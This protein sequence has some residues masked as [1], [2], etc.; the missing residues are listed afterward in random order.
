MSISFAMHQKSIVDAYN[1]VIDDK[2][3]ID[4]ALFSYK[5]NNELYLEETGDGG[6]EELESEFNSGKIQYAFV[7]ITDPNTKMNKF[8]LIIWQGDGVP[9][10]RKGSCANHVR[11]VKRFF[12]NHHIAIVARNED[13]V[14][15]GEIMKQVLKTT[16]NFTFIAPSNNSDPQKNV[17]SVY[18]PIKPIEEIKNTRNQKFWNKMQQEEESRKNEE[19]KLAI[20]KDKQQEERLK[21]EQIRSEE[22]RKKIEKQREIE[23]SEKLKAQKIADNYKEIESYEK[24]KW[25]A[26]QMVK[27]SSSHTRLLWQERENDKNQQLNNRVNHPIKNLSSS[28]IEPQQLELTTNYAMKVNDPVFK[29]TTNVND[30]VKNEPEN[31]TQQQ[32][33]QRI[34]EDQQ[35]KEFEAAKNKV[36]DYEQ[37]E[38]TSESDNNNMSSPGQSITVRALY[39]YQAADDTEI[40]FDP[41]DFITNVEQIDEGWWQGTGPDGNFGLFPANYV[42]II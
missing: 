24:N 15:A 35:T 11:D 41:D 7:S 29:Q 19:K 30:I 14:Q 26:R 40:S 6:L 17:S 4:W 34:H 10:T 18:K 13:E 33:Q 20:M 32:S 37:V 2:E 3:D 42:E 16:S 1:Q 9:A 27:Q 25:E 5:A 21:E 31:K 12:K 36:E 22:N 8:L 23:I 28:F 38:I 39:D